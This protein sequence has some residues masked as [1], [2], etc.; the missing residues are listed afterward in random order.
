L[1]PEGVA[2]EAESLSAAQLDVTFSL[3]QL[4]VAIDVAIAFQVSP[5]GH[6]V[7]LLPND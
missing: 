1:L 5:I 4:Q 7:E 3:S 2:S 6:A